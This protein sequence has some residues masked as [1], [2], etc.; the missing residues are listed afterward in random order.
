MKSYRWKRTCNCG[1]E[2]ST[3]STNRV[4]CHGCLPKCRETHYFNVGKQKK[5]PTL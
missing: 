3:H 5:V 2:F 1:K 4:R